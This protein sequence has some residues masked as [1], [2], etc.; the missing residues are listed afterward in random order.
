MRFLIDS[1]HEGPANLVGPTAVTSAQ[2]VSAISGAY[3]HHSGI[4]VPSWALRAAIGPAADDLLASQ[5]GVPGVL[6]SLGFEW[7][8]PTIAEAARYVAQR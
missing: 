1:E 8:H 4:P 2:L 6:N 7:T 3:G 5:N